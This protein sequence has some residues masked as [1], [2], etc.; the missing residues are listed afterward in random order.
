MRTGQHQEHPTFEKVWKSI[1]ETDKMIQENARK[2]QQ[3]YE[4]WENKV[5]LL[6]GNN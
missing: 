3:D 5:T 4:Q 1:Q 2:H 6:H